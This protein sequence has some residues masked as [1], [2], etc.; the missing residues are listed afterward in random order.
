M[1]TD[2]S[3]VSAVLNKSASL[4]DY[5]LSIS[6]QDFKGSVEVVVVDDC[7]TDSSPDIVKLASEKLGNENLTIRLIRNDQNV[8][9]CGCRNKGLLAASGRILCVVDADCCL[10]PNFVSSHVAAHDDVGADVC[11]GPMGIEGQ[12]RDIQ[13]LH[14]A[15]AAASDKA[16]KEMRLQFNVEPTAFVNT[17]TRNFS[18]TAAFLDKLGEPLFDEAFSYSLD[19]NSGF[20]WEDIE[21]GYR[22]YRLGAKISFSRTAVSVHKTHP[23]EVSDQEKA[24]RSAKNFLK[25]MRKH[26]ELSLA[27]PDW[28]HSTYQKIMDWLDRYD[29][30]AAEERDG[31]AEHFA[32]SHRVVRPRTI[33]SHPKKKVLTT[34]WHIGHQY[35][36]WKLPYSFTLL[37]GL[38]GF[39]SAWDYKSRPLP[40]N[41][42]FLNVNEKQCNFNDYDFAIL[43]FDEFILRPYLYPKHSTHWGA[44]FEY[45]KRFNGKKIAICHGTPLSQ[46]DLN[47]FGRKDEIVGP[48]IAAKL[49]AETYDVDKL[50]R[51]I[52]D[53]LSDCLV[54]CNSLQ[55]AKE[56]GFHRSHVIWH[57]FDPI[58]YPPIDPSDKII[59]VGDLEDRPDYRGGL[60]YDKVT[61]R[62][63]GKAFLL[64]GKRANSVQKPSVTATFDNENDL[65]LAHYQNYVHFVRNFGIFFNPTARSPMP[66]VRGEAMMLGQAVVTTSTHDADRF[67][68]HGYNGFLCDEPDHAVEVLNRLVRDPDLR[69]RV[70][71]R[72]RDTAMELFHV[73]NYMREWEE[74]I[75]R[76]IDGNATPPATMAGD[77]D[78]GQPWR[79]TGRIIRNAIK[80]VLLVHGSEGGTRTWRVDHPEAV[81][82]GAGMPV[83]RVP[84]ETFLK[85]GRE[86]IAL[87]THNI[88]IFHRTPFSGRLGALIS[89]ARAKNIVCL[90]DFDDVTFSQAYAEQLVRAGKAE[91]GN[92]EDEAKRFAALLRVCNGATCS[93]A[94]LAR[95]LADEGIE[96]VGLLPNCL[97]QQLLTAS[98]AARAGRRGA[99]TGG[100]VR[101]GYASGSAT[102]N[103]DFELVRP[104]LDELLRTHPNVHLDL[105]GFL[106]PGEFSPEV[107]GRVHQHRFV[108]HWELPFQLARF[109]INIAPLELNPFNECK[110]AIK[111]IEAAV[112][113]VPTVAS[114]TEPFREAIEHG[115]TGF[116]AGSP[117]EWLECL[118]ALIRDGEL[119]ERIATAAADSCIAAYSPQAWLRNFP[120]QMEAL[121]DAGSAGTGVDAEPSRPLTVPEH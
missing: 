75:A 63:R 8:G 108:E 12:G 103:A 16:L 31:L 38:P 19:A 68:D 59:T 101:I 37:T 58:H 84:L 74:L 80:G 62:L 27:A 40:D 113:G 98:E 87:G 88:I 18:I 70:G 91:P 21:M 119:R 102:H 29:I 48:G 13:A 61:E 47:L 3:I 94:P 112:A 85:S 24:P 33:V 93:T 99:A 46:R 118:D 11:I 22:L 26:P 81:L 43:H 114:P 4:W 110:S 89:E 34:R 104:I 45:M 73:N 14:G 90:A 44:A 66:R 95:L 23:P 71:K 92:A 20:G 69:R 77:E 82:R 6:R 53:A 54:V 10:S 55:A 39:G 60:F 28:A 51:E 42:N 67:I 25:L 2:F 78:R 100:I 97:S 65:G 116:L 17:V 79:R 32:K 57:G 49:E 105:I 15:F 7:S 5:F 36:L 111:F 107:A 9:N 35:D 56:W 109:D 106:D 1:S 52:V 121:L 117:D 83:R 115:V 120:S 76:E 96:R 50:R 30:S 41:A 86:E 72:A 64:G